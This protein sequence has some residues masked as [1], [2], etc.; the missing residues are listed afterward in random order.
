MRF[1]KAWQLSQ[2]GQEVK[3]LYELAAEIQELVD[4]KG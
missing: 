2:T 4:D 1:F 3:E